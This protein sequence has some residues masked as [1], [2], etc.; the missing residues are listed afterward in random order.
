MLKI[1]ESSGIDTEQKAAVLQQVKAERPRR[2]DD[3]IGSLSHSKLH[4]VVITARDRKPGKDIRR[5]TRKC[6]GSK[7]VTTLQKRG[8]LR[9]AIGV[10]GQCQGW[11]NQRNQVSAGQRTQAYVEVPNVT[12]VA[13]QFGEERTIR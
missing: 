1:Q 6:K 13:W 5:D 9:R 2:Q 12:E 3:F 4:A 7:V 10:W 11:T 8:D